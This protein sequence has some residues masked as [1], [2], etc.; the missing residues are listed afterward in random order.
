MYSSYYV[1]NGDSRRPCGLCLA[2]SQINRMAEG[3]GGIHTTEKDVSVPK[4]TGPL[5]NLRPVDP[6]DK[7]VPNLWHAS[8]RAPTSADEGDGT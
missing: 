8:L 7:A 1:L 4:P 2:T 3:G 6:Q 5:R